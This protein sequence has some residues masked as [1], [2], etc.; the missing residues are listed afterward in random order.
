[1]ANSTISVTFKLDGDAAS[2][3]DLAKDANGLKDAMQAALSEAEKLN[4]SLIN[5]SQSVQAL[6]STSQ[7]LT[8]LNGAF[9]N[10]ISDGRDFNKA[11][12]VVNTMAG[13]DAEGFDALTDKVADLSKEIPIARDELANGLYQ[14]ISNG[15]PEDNWIDFLNKSAKSSVGGIAD[16]GQAVTVTSTIIKNYGLEWSAAEEIQDKIQTTAKNGVTSFEQLASA[17]PRVSGNAAQLGVSIDE[18]MAVFATCTGVTGNTAEVSTQLAAVFKSLV[19]PSSEAAKA[20]EAMGISFNA[21][22]IKEAGGLDNFLKALDVTITEYASK[23]G[24]LKETI[25]G[26]LF[27]SAEALRV[28]TSLTGEQ[29]AKFTENIGAMANST[30]AI[31]DAFDQMASTS[32]AQEQLFH[33]QTAAIS[34][35]VEK[36][37]GGVAPYLDFAASSTVAAV[38]GITL[39][40]S[41]SQVAV[42]MKK[43]TTGA[44]LGTAALRLLGLTSRQAST[45]MKAFASSEHAATAATITLKV[46]IR[47]LLIATG[48]GAAL[49]I[50]TAIIEALMGASDD[51]SDS[52]NG[53]D[54]SL[55]AF[56]SAAGEAKVEIDKDIAALKNLIDANA[57][58]TKAVD[59]L[60]RKYGESFGYYKTA[61]EWYDILVKKSEAYCK[62]IGYEAQARVIA[63]KKAEREME[64][65]EI[66]RKK[67]Q[68]EDNGTASRTY[69]MSHR[70]GG[71]THHT[72]VNEDY[73]KLVDAEKAASAEVETLSSQWEECQGNIKASV[74]ELN[75]A[76]PDPQ[77]HALSVSEMSYQQLTDAIS[78]NEKARK[79][80]RA[81]QVSERKE[82]LKQNAALQSRKK[83]MEQILGLEKSGGSGSSR[84]VVADP[85][86]YEQLGINIEAYKK[87]LTTANTEE[88]AIIREKIQAWTAMR[89]QIEITLK[90]ADRPLSL[91]T[92]QDFDRE[93]AYQRALRSQATQENLAGIDA[94]IRRLNELRSAF[95]LASFTPIP[96]DQIKSYKELNE[97]LSHYNSLLE[98]ADATER[99]HI[100]ESING[101]NRLKKSWDDTLASMERPADISALNTIKD[102]DEAIT[103]YQTLQKTQTADEI[104]NTQKVIDALEKKRKAL[105]RGVEISGMKNEVA[106]LSGMK[107]RD[108]QIKIEAIGLDGLKGKIKELNAMLND[109]DHPVTATQRKDIEGLIRTYE[110]Y[111]AKLAKSFE[112][113]KNGW[114]SVK[115]VSNAITSTTEALEGNGSAWEK[116]C[117][118]IDG[119]IALYEGIMGVVE[120]INLLTTASNAATVAETAKTAATTAATTAEGVEAGVAEATAL[121]TIPV[122][123]A[124]KLATASFMELAAASY[125]AAHAYIPFAGFGIA[126]GFTT[127]A[128]AMVEAI[129]AMPFA[130]GGVIYGPTLGLMGEYSGAG[131]NPEVVAPL[132][133]LRDLIGSDES[134]IGGNVEFKMKGRYLKGI[135]KKE[136]NHSKRS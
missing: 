134:G 87:K 101:L 124:N 49:V 113:Y 24:Q 106:D 61:G 116:T 8:Q 96:I 48:V 17:L 98:T 131:S 16:L 69:S 105:N 44:K 88:Q 51:A 114:T 32:E 92:L 100:Q 119:F 135:L 136:D 64:L 12:R 90:E 35:L 13:K 2:F 82:L 93:I 79:A 73:Q 39:Y 10:V 133:K 36:V 23:T 62:Q 4:H 21:A 18:L 89:E 65:T 19:K 66:R 14:V 52:V 111:Q 25:Y 56:K 46:A 132:D 70:V 109:L 120:L 78:E 34:D 54:D 75:K 121:A 57:D 40:K 11:M 117:A 28:L 128:V 6:Q 5:W 74:D 123:A 15:V 43:V 26:N 50:L 71:D 94:E 59:E 118:V 129:G 76:T 112:T 97:Q 83:Y 122:I 37:M 47:G 102:L 125:M 126:A 1:M 22:S 58:T 99:V 45:L 30:G 107:G 77:A 55:D 85:Q 72:V 38:N 60:N 20:A 103:Y 31:S 108:L 84:Q 80:L 29:S 110:S 86:T 81:D 42:H 41:L 9:K 130:D 115:G 104:A 3:Q 53:L 27:G 127:A 95:E 7:A 67:K 63:Q 33:N 91:S 68:M